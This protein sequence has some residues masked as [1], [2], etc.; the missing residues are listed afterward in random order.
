[1]SVTVAFSKGP[2]DLN[3][4]LSGPSMDFK[5]KVQ[6]TALGGGKYQYKWQVQFDDSHVNNNYS[7]S[8]SFL[9]DQLEGSRYDFADWPIKVS[10]VSVRFLDASVDAPAGQWNDSYTYSARMDST[11]PVKVQLQVYDPCSSDWI[12]KQTKDAAVGTAT[13]LN[14]TL[15][16]FAYECQEMAG[17]VAKYRFK[18]SFAGEEIASSR[19]YDGPRFLGAKPTLISFIP[20]GDPLVVYVSEDGASIS[21]SATVDYGAGQGQ[22]VLRLTGPDGSLKLEEESSGIA[23]G[24]DSYRYDWSLPFN[25]DDAEK[26][27]NLSLVYKHDTLSGE[28]PLIEKAVTVLPVSIEFGSALVFPDSGKW[29]DT[30]NYSVPVSSSV[31]AEVKLEVFNPCSHAWVLRKSERLS[32]GQSVL[33]MTAQPLRSSCPDSEA[34]NSS[35]RFTAGFAGRSIESDVYY[36]PFIRGGQPKPPETGETQGTPEVGGIYNDGNVTGNVTPAFGVIQAWDEKDPLHELKYTFQLQNNSKAPTSIELMVRPYGTNASWEIKGDKKRFNP[37]TGSVSWTLK[38]FWDAPFLGR[39][40]YMFLI[41]GKETRPFEGPEIIAI[42]SN[43]GDDLDG[44][45]HNFW[46][47][48]DSS[49]N[50]TVCLVGGDTK[51]PENI[52]KW[53]TKGQ[54]QDYEYGSGE[55]KYEWQLEAGKEP[56]YYDFDV[57]GEGAQ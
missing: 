9:H 30:F 31:D 40:E 13:A 26:S 37:S 22:A 29:N 27:F 5:S 6:G 49:E 50:L 15:R 52:K 16:P 25:E 18:A 38:P 35:F 56:P 53:T 7:L 3:V 12:N 21:V 43:A 2:G 1:M 33:N 24:V 20:D 51:L 36:G 46:A 19:A 4:M 17:K 42:I 45:I 28:Y 48:V 23:M 54:C 47:T 44:K 8:L 55:Q 41:D 10:P 14:W 32:S 39:S 11:V 57:K 34:E